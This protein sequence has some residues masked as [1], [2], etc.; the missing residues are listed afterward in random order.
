MQ[1]PRASHQFFQ[2]VF[3]VFLMGIIAWLATG[4]QESAPLQLTEQDKQLV[5]KPWSEAHLIMP[6]STTHYVA[7]SSD[8]RAM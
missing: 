8:L 6:V 1:S 5:E 2:V 4:W 3:V 7:P